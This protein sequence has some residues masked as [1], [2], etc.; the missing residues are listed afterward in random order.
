M[1][2]GD[3]YNQQC[4]CTGTPVV[5]VDCVVS[6]WTIGVCDGTSRTDTRTITTQPKNGGKVCPTLSR[7]RDCTPNINCEV[8]QWNIGECLEND[9]RTDTRI[10]TTQPSGT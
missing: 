9:T 6:T 3:T 10:I 5:P 8:S 1:T 7:T 2:T 4:V